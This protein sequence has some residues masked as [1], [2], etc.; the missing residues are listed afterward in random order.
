MNLRLQTNYKIRFNSQ[1]IVMVIR[2]KSHHFGIINENQLT[3]DYDGY[4]G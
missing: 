3:I 1:M 4:N 2:V